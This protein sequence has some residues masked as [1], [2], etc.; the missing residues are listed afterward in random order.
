[1][2]NK[3]SWKKLPK[4]NAFGG[5]YRWDGKGKRIYVTKT[6]YSVETI[7]NNKILVSGRTSSLNEAKRKARAY[8]KKNC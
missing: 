5:L 8:M 2:V 1:M 3:C 7:P 4:S 6:G